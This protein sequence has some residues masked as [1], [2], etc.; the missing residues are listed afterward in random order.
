MPAANAWW[1]VF[2]Q[3]MTADGEKAQGFTSEP[4]RGRF[5]QAAMKAKAG[6]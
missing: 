5:G 3:A 2:R 1:T 4:Y 6:A